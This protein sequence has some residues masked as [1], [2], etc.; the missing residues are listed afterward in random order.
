MYKKN[1]FPTTTTMER[2]D[3]NNALLFGEGGGPQ[4]HAQKFASAIAGRRGA[5]LSKLA[6]LDCAA[7]NISS[8][9]RHHQG[10]NNNNNNFDGGEMMVLVEENEVRE[11]KRRGWLP[12]PFDEVWEKLMLSALELKRNQFEKCYDYH[13]EAL[14]CFIKDF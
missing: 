6:S 8:K 10:G 11:C 14:A 3:D 2:D 13:N 1:D 9:K 12:K 5:E 7:K 4:S